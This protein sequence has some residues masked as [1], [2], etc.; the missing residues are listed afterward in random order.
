MSHPTLRPI[1]RLSPRLPCTTLIERDRAEPAKLIM[2]RQQELH[3]LRLPAV[4]GVS[5]SPGEHA[6]N[7]GVAR[8]VNGP[9]QVP[10]ESRRTDV[11][12]YTF[13]DDAAPA[14]DTEPEIASS[15]RS[16][17]RG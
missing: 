17:T 10:R 12:E 2:S 15:A 9:L 5:E 7:G 3:L 1:S 8:C 14:A 4:Y 13:H 11:E 6:A 16:A